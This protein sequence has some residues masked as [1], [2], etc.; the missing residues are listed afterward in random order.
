MHLCG[1]D[2]KPVQRLTF[3]QMASGEQLRFRRLALEAL[4]PVFRDMFSIGD[5]THDAR[6]NGPNSVPVVD[7]DHVNDDQKVALTENAKTLSLVKPYLDLEGDHTVPSLSREAF[8][9][10]YCF[11]HKYDVSC[12]LEVQHRV[13]A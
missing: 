1:R 10:V 4:S 13:Q 8:W 2:I 5:A 3:H 7:V 9:P 12:S 11:A 6:V